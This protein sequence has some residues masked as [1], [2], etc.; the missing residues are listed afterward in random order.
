MSKSTWN[1]G[2][3][4][5]RVLIADDYTLFRETLKKVLDSEPCFIVV[6]EARDGEETIELA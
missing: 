5:I 4:G 2:R 1:E 3:K 6:G